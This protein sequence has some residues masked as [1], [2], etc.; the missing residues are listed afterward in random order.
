MRRALTLVL[1][2]VI[3]ALAPAGALAAAASLPDIEDEVMCVT[4][5]V[6]LNTAQSPQADRE[7]AYIRDLIRQGKDKEQIKAALVSEYG[8]EVLATPS[9]D[10]FG[11]AAYIVPI[12][13]I[14]LLAAGL[15]VALPRRRRRAAAGDGPAPDDAETP[16]ISAEDAARLDA[17]LARFD[18]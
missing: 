15:A 16:E 5:R 12:V 13:L 6:P 4:C 9:D 7:R 2:P 3:L 1:V 14:V 17:D 18:A 8:E 11:R 10:G